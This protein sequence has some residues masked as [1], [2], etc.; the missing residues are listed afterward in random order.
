[1]ETKN[2]GYK[3][4]LAERAGDEA[5]VMLLRLWP[6]FLKV[7]VGWVIYQI[8]LKLKKRKVGVSSNFI[9][10]F[11]CHDRLSVLLAWRPLNFVRIL[12]L[13]RHKCWWIIA[14]QKRNYIWNIFSWFLELLHFPPI[15][16]CLSLELSITEG[17]SSRAAYELLQKEQQ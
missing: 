7:W 3:K 1:M 5:D 14:K 17:K 9:V 2:K 15:V 11:R 10:V 16:L 12:L 6:C 8:H 4:Y 13:L